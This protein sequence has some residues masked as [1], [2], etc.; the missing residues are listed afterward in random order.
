M[1]IPVSCLEVRENGTACAK[2]KQK[3]GSTIPITVSIEDIHKQYP[4]MKNIN[5]LSALIG[6][7]KKKGGTYNLPNFK[8]KDKRKE[9]LE[10]R[11]EEERWSK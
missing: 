1:E 7:L 9:R 6:L 5:N 4:H 8:C 2:I 10:R 3:N 11:A